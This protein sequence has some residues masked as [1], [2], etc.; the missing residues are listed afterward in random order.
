MRTESIQQ[1]VDFAQVLADTGAKIIRREFRM[2]ADY[3]VKEDQSPVTK[4]DQDVEATQR[5]L[6]LSHFP[7]HGI[8]GEEFGHENPDSEYTWLLDPI[9]GTKA[10]AAGLNSFASLITLAR[11]GKPIIGIID[12][13]ITNERWIGVEGRP[14]TFNGRN[15]RTRKCEHLK[16]AV[17]ATCSPDNYNQEGKKA[18][19]ALNNATRWTVYGASCLAPGML[20][21][22]FIDIVIE[23]GLDPYD[24]C[25]IVPIIEGAGGVITDL[26]GAPL[27]IKSGEYMLASCTKQLHEKALN[28][29]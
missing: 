13:P 9:D 3:I 22:G 17:L 26:E 20:A 4:V 24:Y 18:Y 19:R 14:T 5:K 6:I 28:T 12:Q 11:N 1:F 27:T 10:F 2:S 15:I 23:A 8:L 7:N 29:I 16:Q 21:S 25:P